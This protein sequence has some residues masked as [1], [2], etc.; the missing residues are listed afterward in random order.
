MPSR[1]WWRCWLLWLVAR[2]VVLERG[3]RRTLAVATF[4]SMVGSGLFMTGAALFFTR[5]VG[6]SVGQVA[7]A[8]GVAAV[9]GLVAGVPAGRVADRYGPRE[10]YL[11]I[12]CVQAAAMAALVLVH[13]FWA[14]VL[15]I[16]LTQLA[17]SAGAAA[18]GPLTRGFAGPDPTR[19]RSYLRAAANLAGACGAVMAGVVVQLDTR[20]AYMALVLANALSFLLCAAVVTRLP[21]LP[22]VGEPERGSVSGVPA[23]GRWGV[24]KDVPFMVVTALDSLLSLQGHVLV[25]A[26]PLWIVGH[27]QTPHWLIGVCGV[28]NT[29]MVVVFQVRASRGVVDNA[30]AGRGA[31]R[32]GVAFLLGMAAIAAAAGAPGWL[33]SVLIVAGV[34]VHTV[35]ELWHVAASF[36]LSFGLAPARAQG[37]YSGLHA[38][39][40][41]LAGS[42]APSVLALFCITWGVPGWLALGCVFVLA[43][44][45]MPYAV[46]WA[47]RSRTAPS[48]A[49]AVPA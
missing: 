33:A 13:S 4:V 37:Q 12:Q 8:M 2:G 20:G 7:V 31:V 42:L 25:F 9:V 40:T 3:P 11:V 15:T 44:V 5:S 38:T 6:L 29:L 32:S 16:S 48:V 27:S 24:L 17:A 43:G 36:E 41:G 19:Y 47:V 1:S 34:V 26:L 23:A 45:A 10:T 28:V 39:G 21:H 46:R 14:F 18:R 22:P 30:S 35:G 49:D